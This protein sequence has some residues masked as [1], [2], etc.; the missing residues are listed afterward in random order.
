MNFFRKQILLWRNW[1]SLDVRYNIFSPWSTKLFP[2]INR[3]LIS[4]FSSNQYYTEIIRCEA[5]FFWYTYIHTTKNIYTIRSQLWES[6]WWI[7]LH[8][9]SATLQFL[10]QT[11]HCR[12]AKWT[13]FSL[14][15]PY[16]DF[17]SMNQI[18]HTTYTH[19][20]LQEQVY[21]KF[22]Q[23]WKFIRSIMIAT[24]LCD[25]CRS[26]WA[27]HLIASA[28][29]CHL[30]SRKIESFIPAN[31][32]NLSIRIHVKSLDFN[33]KCFLIQVNVNLFL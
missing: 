32:T 21:W 2:T 19:A 22:T 17:F 23:E 28:Q 1:E 29:N 7:F 14:S 11:I 12:Y 31:G 13:S 24:I 16:G 18:S 9:N 8:S 26:Q 3:I 20:R 27:G 5:N 4:P 10:K 25:V 33:G 15:N 6:R 30:E